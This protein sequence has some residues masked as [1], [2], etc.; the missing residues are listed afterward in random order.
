MEVC[1]HR[2]AKEIG[3]S[4]VEV[5]SGEHRLIID[6]G[7]PLDAEKIDKALLLSTTG[8]I[9]KKI[10]AVIISHPH[11]DHYGLLPYIS[12]EIPV[13]MG[14][15]ARRILTDAAPFMHDKWC[16]PAGGQDLVSEECFLLGP[17]K[18]TP[19]L[20]DHS[21]YDAYSLLIEA[22]GRWLLYSGDLRMH[23][24]K[25]ALTKRLSRKLSGLVDT[26]IMEGTTIQ[27]ATD[28]PEQAGNIVDPAANNSGVYN[29]KYPQTESDIEES[30]VM[31]FSAAQGLVLVNCSS[32]NIDRI[33]SIYRACK[34]SGKTL[35][36]DLYTAVVLEA[37]GNS[38]IPQSN[39]PG[40]E[41][42]VPQ[43]QRVLILKNKMFK[44][45]TKHSKKRIF[46]EGLEKISPNGVLLF[47]PLLMNDLDKGD[48]QTKGSLLK[49]ASFI[50]SQWSDYWERASFEAVRKWLHKHNIEKVHIHTSGHAS[51]PDLQEFVRT[52]NPSCV[53]PI[54]TNNPESFH[55]YF[56]RVELHSDGEKWE[57]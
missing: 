22:D 51:I 27:G 49:G 40:I 35:I 12:P 47:R 48:I 4:C 14:T 28:V 45:L 37:T 5:T 9:E 36:I 1:I 7:L 33:V 29:T 19:Y 52:L 42:F 53:V 31:E 2:G 8:L 16:V 25:R 26:L 30:F 39:W 13:I 34:R 56:D 24:R 17:F 54:H 11:L 32:Q 44:T 18:I 57:A 21:A 50:Y 15:N 10:L 46:L 6:L 38:N 43:S 23:G 20:V 55:K 3:G 41:L